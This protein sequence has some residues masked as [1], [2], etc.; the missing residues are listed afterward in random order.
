MIDMLKKKNKSIFDKIN[1]YLM[2]RGHELVMS[3]YLNDY[4]G[5]NIYIRLDFIRK[6]SVYKVVWVDLNFFNEKNIENYINIQMMTKFISLRVVEKMMAIED[7]GGYSNRDDILGDRVEILTYFTDN[8]KE[9]VFDR[10]LPKKWDFLIDPLAMIFT[11][12]PR[13]ME[14]F[15]N[16]IFA[17]FDGTE[18]RYNYMKPIK[19]DFLKG[20][21]SKIFKKHII[22]RGE[23]YFEEGRVKFLEKT[24][25]NKILAIVE[26]EEEVPYLVVLDQIKEDYVL[27]WCNCKCDFYCKHIYAALK[28]L[29]AGQFN[30][31]YKVKYIG[32]EESL[33]ERVTT[34]NFQLCFG[35]EDDKLLLITSDGAFFPAPIIQKG[36]VMFEVIEDDDECFL[37]KKIEE[38]KM[39]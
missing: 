5:N 9:F 37:S 39:R 25:E 6:L 32:K 8:Q 31:F 12:L 10:F 21:M 17:S 7:E 29:R 2:K 23:K 30:D 38:Y 4:N 3:I 14:V 13:S 34:T 36:K 16:E 11:Y 1:D 33:L 18:E 28:A 26:N 22:T 15:L 24:S 27:M 35:I 19:F 20:D